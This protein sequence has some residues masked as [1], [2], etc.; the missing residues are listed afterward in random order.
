MKRM[1]F[2]SESF[3]Q[4]MRGMDLIVVLYQKERV[5]DPNLN[6]VATYPVW[7][8]VTTLRAL[9]FF[10]RDGLFYKPLWAAL[11]T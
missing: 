1:F 8:L 3:E 11:I 9:S 5:F 7:V 4:T 6:I 2:N 10:I